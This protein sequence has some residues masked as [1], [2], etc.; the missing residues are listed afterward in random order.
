MS[1]KI[2]KVWVDGESVYASTEEGLQASYPFAMW[3]RLANATEAQ[4]QDFYLSYSGIHW[5]QIDED[6]SFEGMFSNAGLCER[7]EAEDSVYYPIS[8]IDRA[9][10]DNSHCVAED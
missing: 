1:Y 5:P 4:R 3:P 7:S 10:S 8:Y 6:L 2:N 9:E